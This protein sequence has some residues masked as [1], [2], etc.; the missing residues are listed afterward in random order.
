MLIASNSGVVELAGDKPRSYRL[1]PAARPYAT[2]DPGASA[3]A[4]PNAA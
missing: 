3:E 1:A 2:R 4:A